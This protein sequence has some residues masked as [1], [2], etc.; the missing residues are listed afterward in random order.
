MSQQKCRVFLFGQRLQDTGEAMWD[1]IAIAQVK[2]CHNLLQLQR[3]SDTIRSDTIGLS[4]KRFFYL[5]KALILAVTRDLYF[6]NEFKHIFMFSDRWNYRKVR[7]C[8]VRW[9]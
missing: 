5:T 3:L 8:V 4:G 2:S 7:A 6:M 9:S 1:Y